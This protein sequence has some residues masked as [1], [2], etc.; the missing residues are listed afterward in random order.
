MWR[1]NRVVWWIECKLLGP[2]KNDYYS[3]GLR[4]WENISAILG[5]RDGGKDFKWENYKS[6]FQG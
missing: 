2:T 5:R 6:M 4:D 3:P 1:L